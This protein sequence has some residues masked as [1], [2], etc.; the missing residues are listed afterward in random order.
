MVLRLAALSTRDLG[1]EGVAQGIA[2]GAVPTDIGAL[3]VTLQRG[4]AELG[5]NCPVILAFHPRLRRLIEEFQGQFL[6]PPRA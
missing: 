5:V 6:D 3:Q 2:W 1:P 4:T